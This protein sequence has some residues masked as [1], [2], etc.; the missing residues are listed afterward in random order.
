MLGFGQNEWWS[1]QL[2][3]RT[4]TKISLPKIPPKT[5]QSVEKL[6]SENFAKRILHYGTS[7]SPSQPKKLL[8]GRLKKSVRTSENREV[9]REIRA[10]TVPTFSLVTPRNVTLPTQRKPPVPPA[11]GQNSTSKSLLK[12]PR[13]PLSPIRKFKSLSPKFQRRESRSLSPVESSRSEKVLKNSYKS[14][15]NKSPLTEPKVKEKEKE[16]QLDNFV[17]PKNTIRKYD[18]YI[19]PSFLAIFSGL[20]KA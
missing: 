7:V 8:P 6:G 18:T 16:T 12:S 9:K 5:N 14:F 20:L 15:N 10:W 13:T 4:K 19:Q 3:Q 11:P 1:R 17:H 2:A